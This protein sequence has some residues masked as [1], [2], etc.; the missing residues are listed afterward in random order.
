MNY[1]CPVDSRKICINTAE[2]VYTPPE[3]TIGD[4]SLVGSGV[5]VINIINVVT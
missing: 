3:H 2:E 4:A 1:I 5:T